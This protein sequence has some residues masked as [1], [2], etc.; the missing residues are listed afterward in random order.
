MV[1]LA[2]A[3]PT[4]AARRA[5]QFEAFEAVTQNIARQ[6]ETLRNQ[7]VITQPMLLRMESK[8]IFRSKTDDYLRIV[9]TLDLPDDSWLSPAD[10][11]GKAKLE[12]YKRR[13]AREVPG[14]GLSW[15]KLNRIAAEMIGGNTIAF[16]SI[17]RTK[18]CWYATEDDYVAALLREHMRMAITPGFPRSDFRDVYEV[19]GTRKFT[20]DGFEFADDA[21]GQ[22]TMIAYLQKT[23]GGVIK[24]VD[25][26]PQRE[27]L[28][29]IET[30]SDFVVDQPDIAMDIA[31]YQAYIEEQREKRAQAFHEEQDAKIA[32]AADIP[33]AEVQRRR[34]GRKA[35]PVDVPAN[36]YG[37]VDDPLDQFQSIMDD[38]PESHEA[39][40]RT[41]EPPFMDPDLAEVNDVDGD[42]T[43]LVEGVSEDGGIDEA[44]SPADGGAGADGLPEAG[45]Y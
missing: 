24:I 36:P 40:L 28:A 22:A 19:S 13:T 31:K 14:V 37:I 42:I 16:H 27:T 33:V 9:V 21:Q 2:A 3:S 38:K 10:P 25:N 30:N 43:D 44:G 18:E 15:G 34:G 20:V 5:A 45:S 35:K 11:Y 4:E 17:A 12:R 1:A 6:F 39:L 41:S 29:E 26:T 32:A 8:Y 7:P 23:K